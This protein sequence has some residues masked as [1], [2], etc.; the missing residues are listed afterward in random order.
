MTNTIDARFYKLNA[1]AKPKLRRRFAVR[2]EDL[3]TF[4]R[5]AKRGESFV[6][7]VGLLAADRMD[8]KFAK[9]ITPSERIVDTIASIAWSLYE[10]RKVTLVQ[11][12]IGPETFQYEMQRL[13]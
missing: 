7:H 6:Y 9:A 13:A 2:P 12:Q 8:F 5:S 1:A 4:V 3:D 11:R 10:Q